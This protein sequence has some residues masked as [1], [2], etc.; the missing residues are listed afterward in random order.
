MPTVQKRPSLAAIG[1]N[2]KG[3]ADN[4]EVD[5]INQAN[6]RAKI[7]ASV[8]PS[9]FENDLKEFTSQASKVSGMHLSGIQAMDSNVSF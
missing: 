2:A 4:K 5:A 7:L 6:K 8:K 1:R 3:G 9:A